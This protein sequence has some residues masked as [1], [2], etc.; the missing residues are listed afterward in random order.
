[1]LRLIKVSG[2]SLE[3]VY[4]EGDYVL[5]SCLPILLGRLHPG[6]AVVFRHPSLGTLVKLVEQVNA[7]QGE[8]CVV[9]LHPD[10][11]DSQHFGPVA[12]RDLVGKVVG[13]VRRG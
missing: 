3:P 8:I 12:R 2:Q 10:S 7:G 9:G 4:R 11:V 1:M 13:V 5:V 6:D